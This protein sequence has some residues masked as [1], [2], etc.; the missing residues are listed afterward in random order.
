MTGPHRTLQTM[1]S[2]SDDMSDMLDDARRPRSDGARAKRDRRRRVREVVAVETA[3]GPIKDLVAKEQV[4]VA[5]L[6]AEKKQ[7]EA[8]FVTE[9]KL[10]D[11]GRGH[12]RRR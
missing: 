2:G 11:S 8:Q 6:A 5:T 4:Q 12:G 7:I 9:Q 3:T 1:L 10:Q